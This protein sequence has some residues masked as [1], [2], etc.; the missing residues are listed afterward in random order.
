[1]GQGAHTIAH[2]M[3]ISASMRG[4]K[5]PNYRGGAGKNSQKVRSFR[6]SRLWKTLRKMALE[7]DKYRCVVCRKIGKCGECGR[8]SLEV[9]HI[10]SASKYPKLY[11]ELSNLRSLCRDCHKKSDNYG[12]KLSMK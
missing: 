6:E 8:S 10:K 5:N 4:K 1:M 2:K 9:D 12:R 3:K 7:R 11:F